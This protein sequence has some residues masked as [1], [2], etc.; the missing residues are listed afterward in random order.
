MAFNSEALVELYIRT[1]IGDMDFKTMEDFIYGILDE[2][3]SSLSD[4]ELISEIGE[5][6]PELLIDVTL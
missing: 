5:H 1:I 3:F 2:R 4:G 6:Y